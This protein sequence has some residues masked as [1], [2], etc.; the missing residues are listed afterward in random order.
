MHFSL[1]SIAISLLAPSL[2]ALA[3]PAVTAATAATA[4][5]VP[6]YTPPVGVKLYNATAGYNATHGLPYKTN[7]HGPLTQRDLKA[8]QAYSGD[9][10]WFYPGLGACGGTNNQ[11]E[12][13]VALNSPQWNNKANCWRS[14]TIQANGRQVP[15]AIVDLVCCTDRLKLQLQNSDEM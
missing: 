13:V 10:T 9:A 14:I 7:V 3:A 12:H 15:A 5:L 8:R 6:A 1:F 2:L 11:W 4:A